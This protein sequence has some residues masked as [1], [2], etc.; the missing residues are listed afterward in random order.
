MACW[1]LS[2]RSIENKP[3]GMIGQVSRSVEFSFGLDVTA[4]IFE[5][6]FEALLEHFLHQKNLLH[7]RSILPSNA[8]LRFVLADR[9]EYESIEHKIK[10]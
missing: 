10:K 3:I 6:D 2:S 9:T 5:L 4:V 7:F 1:S 8:I